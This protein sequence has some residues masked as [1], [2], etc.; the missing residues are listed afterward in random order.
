MAAHIEIPLSRR[1]HSMQASGIRK[2]FDLAQEIRNPVN[3]SIGQPHFD[4][5]DEV[6]AVAIEAIRT[7][8]NSYTQTQG[9]PELREALLRHLGGRYDASEILVASGVCGALSLAYLALLDAGDE[10]VV[11]DPYFVGYKQL[12]FLCG[13][14]PVF[15]DTYPDFSLDPE[16]VERAV[17]PRT[18]AVIFSSPA[19]PTGAVF[20]A[21]DLRALAE[22]ARRHDLLV[23]SD[24]IY[25]D[26][27][28]DAPFQSITDFY[29]KTLVLNGFS[30][31]HAMTG[32]RLAWAAGPRELIAAMTK[33]Q[34]FTY[35]CAPSFAQIAGAAA[36]GR[37]PDERIAEYKAKR[38]R[39]HAGLVAAGYDVQKPA[40]AF[41]IF[42]R[43][44]WGT[45]M[46][47]AA[48]AVKKELLII[49][50]SVFSEANTHV[51]ISYAATD[52][53]IDRGLE[54]LSELV[55]RP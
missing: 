16:R 20:S 11:L 24:E 13:A 50:G 17:S 40:G 6:K 33:L 43:A 37:L 54:I 42:P 45:D 23:I 35:V 3:L 1:V 7:G 26:Y 10:I 21:A 25:C 22:V 46:D 53:T 52:E 34:Q 2:V 41:Y 27:A 8:K 30:K 51:R 39:I 5:P 28:Y 29:E 36:L 32:W 48:A 49:P 55:K 38:D 15:V 9:G 47:F 14:R 44:P 31:S 4:V 18:R 19:N 12:A